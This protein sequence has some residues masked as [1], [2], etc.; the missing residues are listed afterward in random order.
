MNEEEIKQLLAERYNP[1]EIV[2]ILGLDTEVL[3]V[4]LWDYIEDNLDKFNL[5]VATFDEI[6]ERVYGE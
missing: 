1:E 3:V 5:Q 4:L 6:V 2:D